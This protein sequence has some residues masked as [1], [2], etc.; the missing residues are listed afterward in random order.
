[1]RFLILADGIDYG[2]GVTNVML[3]Q[4][5]MLKEM[6]HEALIVTLNKC[7]KVKSYLFNEI[8]IKEDDILIHHYSIYSKLC[9]LIK[10]LKNKKIFFYHNITPP[11]LL[12]DGPIKEECIKG[13]NQVKEL[14]YY[15]YYLGVS[16]YNIDQLIKMN[17]TKK[18]D[19][20]G[21]PLTL[22][23]QYKNNKE[24]DNINFLFVGRYIE[25]KRIEDIIDIFTYYHNSINKKSILRIVGNPNLSLEY[26]QLLMDRIEESGCKDN[27]YLMGKVSNEEL[28]NIYSLSDIYLCTSKHEGFCIP[29]L[30]AMSKG[31]LVIATNDGAMKETM[32]NAGISLNTRD[33]YLVSS[34]INS[35]ILDKK[36]FKEII[37]MQYKRIN[38]FTYINIKNQFESLIN[39][40]INNNKE[41][42][43]KEINKLNIQVQGQ[44][45]T[46]YSLALTNRFLIEA[47]N[48]RKDTDVSIR[49]YDGFD[50]YS[51]SRDLVNNLDICKVLFNKTNTNP[52]ISIRGCYP[53][54][55]NSLTGQI[56]LQ[57]F[58][59]EEDRVPEE[60]INDFN[61]NLDGIGAGSEFVKEAL[62]NSGCNIPIYVTGNGVRLPNNIDS[63]KPYKLNTNK[64]NVFLHISSAFPRKGVDVLLETYFE[65]FTSKDDVCLVLKT[66]PNKHNK[67]VELL[68]ELR[69]KYKDY[70]EVIHINE[71]LSESDLYS[72]YK[73]CD[74][75]VQCARGEG[76]GLPIAEAMLLKKPCIVSNNSGMAD[77]SNENTCLCVGYTKQK[78]TSHVANNSNWFEPSRED[79]KKHMYNFI[80]NKE[81][82]DLD[83]KVKNAYELI[84]TKFTWD[85]VANNWILFINEL[86]NKKQKPK[87]GLIT[88]YNSKCGIAEF[89]KYLYDSSNEL[90]DYEIYP[91]KDNELIRNDE[92]YVKD[93][94][95]SQKTK[96]IYNKEFINCL[97]NSNNDYLLFEYNF[98]FF[99]SV[100]LGK[101]INDLY[102]N[103]KVIIEFHNTGDFKKYIN[104]SDLKET[105]N[106]FNKAYKIIVHQDND[107]NNLVNLGFNKEL[108]VVIPHGQFTSKYRSKEEAREI[109]DINSN[110]IVGSY[111]FMLPNKGILKTIEAINL[112]KDKYE[113][114]LFIGSNSLFNA[115][116]SYKY[117]DEIINYIEDND[118]E[119]NVYLFTDFLDKEESLLLLQATDI[120]ALPYDKTNE[121]A[122]GAVRF[123][124]GVK[125]PLITTK[126][127][128]FKEFESCSIQLEDN[129]PSKIAEAIDRLF[130][131]KQLQESL[132]NNINKVIDESSWHSVVVKLLKLLK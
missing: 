123:C 16:K 113:D 39:K 42:E 122:S 8:N 1:M 13:Y 44:F 116:I 43:N 130:K 62:I 67:S 81:S 83:N 4:E 125:K 50:D 91:D 118:L 94:I 75:Y 23:I 35:L 31:L 26:N 93:R 54:S 99:D 111:G 40:Y 6:N 82:L 87:V 66:F 92:I 3:L 52:T 106:N 28:E 76:F 85:N 15:D 2:D 29:L 11:E 10:P 73:R 36:L 127:N 120:L 121:S 32:G 105:I 18:G 19:V 56:N 60:Y 119:N 124:I 100:I 89:S 30:E 126:Q 57:Y 72:L 48:K 47:L 110:H 95:W 107:I 108:L 37:D 70:P 90:I 9:D 114:I 24:D 103:K 58:V 59:W 25:N 12:K 101:Y 45:E 51:P 69:N 88:T 20:I 86:M 79:L 41:I 129:D 7:D 132:T 109:L 46:S 117:H 96:N 131:D 38:D 84:S 49:A 53:P 61:N 80:Y 17:V 5:K 64:N 98:G 22:D 115:D 77:F 78:S 63:I 65:T 14:N 55:T 34:L 21:I 128:M 112:L 68:N 97:L 104:E 71:D 102:L 27:I 74:C 33:P